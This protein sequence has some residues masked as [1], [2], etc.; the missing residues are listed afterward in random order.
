VNNDERERTSGGFSGTS[1]P[2]LGP[3]PP[4]GWP[5]RR[6]AETIEQGQIWGATPHGQ[7]PEKHFEGV[8]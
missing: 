6:G 4:S 1:Y 7:S 3:H 2:L 5:L 8:K